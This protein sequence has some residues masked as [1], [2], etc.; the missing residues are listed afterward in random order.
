M[1]LEELQK[2]EDKLGEIKAVLNPVNGP[3]VC[4]AIVSNVN[5]EM[6]TDLVMDMLVHMG[7]NDKKILKVAQIVKQIQS[8]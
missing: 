2:I 6:L 5:D 4:D 1:T 3:Y 7:Y 8:E